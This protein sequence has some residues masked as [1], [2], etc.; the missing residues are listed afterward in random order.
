MVVARNVEN[1]ANPICMHRNLQ[2]AACDGDVSLV[3]T[4]KDTAPESLGT[5]TANLLNS[6]TKSPKELERHHRYSVLGRN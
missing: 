1:N 2:S 6:M 4:Y 5:K 3:E